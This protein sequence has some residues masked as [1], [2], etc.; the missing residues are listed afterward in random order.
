MNIASSLKD[1]REYYG[2]SRKGYSGNLKQWK[3]NDINTKI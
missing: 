1:K 2:Y 3:E